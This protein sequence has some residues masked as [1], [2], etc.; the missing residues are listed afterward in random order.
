MLFP[1]ELE[2]FH[3]NWFRFGKYKE[4]RFEQIVRNNPNYWIEYE[5]GLQQIKKNTGEQLVVLRPSW[6]G[7]IRE[8]AARINLNHPKHIRSHPNYI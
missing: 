3:Y 1:T 4:L 2:T 5:E 6:K 8:H 7:H